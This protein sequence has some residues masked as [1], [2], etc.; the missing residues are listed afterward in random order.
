MYKLDEDGKEIDWSEIVVD[1]QVETEI[2]SAINQVDE[3][4]LKPI[5]ELVGESISYFDIKLVLAK[6][7]AEVNI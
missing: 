1:D 2:I 7:K 3:E 5:K 4:K 6:L